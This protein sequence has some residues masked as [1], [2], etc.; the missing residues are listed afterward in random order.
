[1][2]DLNQ[3]IKNEPGRYE[4][5]LLRAAIVFQT[6]KSNGAGELDAA[7]RDIQDACQRIRDSV[8]VEY[9]A[10]RILAVASLRQ[11]D[12]KEQAKFHLSEAVRLGLS[13]DAIEENAQLES[14]RKEDWYAP[15]LA[16]CKPP[17]VGLKPTLAEIAMTP[18]GTYLETQHKGLFRWKR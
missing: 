13:R 17:G 4:A 1:V 12:L 7:V 9:Q 6:R 10:A 8:A 18:P 15:L 14:L 5:Y 11:P 3:A 2:T 16:E